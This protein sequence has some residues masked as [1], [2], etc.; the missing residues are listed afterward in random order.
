MTHTLIRRTKGLLRNVA[1]AWVRAVIHTANCCSKACIYP[2]KKV[3]EAF[4]CSICQ[5]R[6]KFLL[7]FLYMSANKPLLPVSQCLLKCLYTPKTRLKV[8]IIFEK[9]KMSF[10]GKSFFSLHRFRLDA[11]LTL[12]Y[13]TLLATE[14]TELSCL[15]PHFADRRQGLCLNL[16]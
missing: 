4:T 5:G 8:K 13:S 16:P 11:K 1:E 3:F 2:Q 10:L 6:N 15:E 9:E 14:R 12:F 7:I